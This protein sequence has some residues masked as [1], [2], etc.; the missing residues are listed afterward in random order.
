MAE[1]ESPTPQQSP[2]PSPARPA[3]RP[4]FIPEKYWDAAAGQVRLEELAKG[5]AEAQSFIGNAKAEARK[6][7]EPELRQ[8][9][10]AELRKALEPELRKALEPEVRKAL[11]GELFKARPAKADDYKLELP[12]DAKDMVLLAE[13]PGKEFQPEPGKSYFFLKKDDPLVKVAREVAYRAG[14]SQADFAKHMLVM[15]QS[16]VGRMPTQEDLLA[17]KKRELEKLGDHGLARVK[18][19]DRWIKA[20]L[21]EE[22]AAALGE[23]LGSAAAI[24][25][26]EMLMEKVGAPKFAPVAGA[27]GNAQVTLAEL[28]AK[29]QDPRYYS[30]PA[31]RTEVTEGY[32]RLFATPAS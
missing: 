20:Q 30:D 6:A 16:L 2:P 15:A 22:K 18:H 25:A 32:K 8:A 26:I 17:E 7:V 9:I 21:P 29:Q 11:E 5:Y 10:D 12:A 14:L 13:P 19:V 31:F 1:N 28:R 23:T 4:E 27:G 3:Q 24:E